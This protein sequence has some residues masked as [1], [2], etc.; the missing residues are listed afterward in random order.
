[1]PEHAAALALEGR[2]AGFPDE[3]RELAAADLEARDGEGGAELDLVARRLEIR[4]RAV[5]GRSHPVGSGRNDHH[6]GAVGAVAK[7]GAGRGNLAKRRGLG[8]RQRQGKAEF[9]K[10]VHTPLKSYYG[11]HGVQ[12]SIK[13]AMR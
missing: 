12:S 11:Y 6:L 8:R 5:L 13:G 9:S 10:R 1:M 3:G 4:Q 7:R 2:V